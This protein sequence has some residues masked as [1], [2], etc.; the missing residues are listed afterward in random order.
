MFFPLD[1]QREEDFITTMPSLRHKA[2]HT[3]SHVRKKKD[4]ED[5]CAVQQDLILQSSPLV[6]PLVCSPDGLLL[7]GNIKNGLLHLRNRTLNF[8]R[9]QKL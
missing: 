6:T 3:K 5:V 4:L 1:L 7:G 8:H 2:L 9:D